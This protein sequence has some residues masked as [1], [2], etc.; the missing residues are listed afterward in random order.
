M[1]GRLHKQTDC[2]K[3]LTKLALTT[4][5]VAGG[6]VACSERPTVAPQQQSEVAYVASVK[7]EPFHKVSCKWAQKISA[8]NLQTFKTR[9]EA[10][11]AGHRPCRVCKP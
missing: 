1:A 9:D 10:I 11:A 2:M 6:L 3:A 4:F 7:R 5:L 8:D